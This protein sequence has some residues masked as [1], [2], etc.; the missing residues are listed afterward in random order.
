MNE[1]RKFRKL[2]NLTQT[3]LGLQLGVKKQI[4]S[5]W[6]TGSARIDLKHA[7][8]LRKIFS[9][10]DEQLSTVM[11]NQTAPRPDDFILNRI[12]EIYAQLDRA[13]RAELLA[14]AERIAENK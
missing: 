6:E 11:D 5:A 13:E 9:L 2:A 10:S 1:L 7:E 8:K 3:E 14:A 4:V 12:T